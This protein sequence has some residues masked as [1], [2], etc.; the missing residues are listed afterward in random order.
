MRAE[1]EIQYLT[2]RQINDD[3]WNDCITKATNG[4]IY[5]YSNYLDAMSDNWDALVL[6][7]YEAVMPLPWRKKWSV[8]YLYQPF[9]TAQLGTF[10]NN[11]SPEIFASLL[12]AVPKKFSFWDLSFNHQN[13]FVVPQFPLHQRSNFIVSLQPSYDD[14]YKG[15]RENVKRNIKKS[16]TYGCTATTDVTINAIIELTNFQVKENAGQDI[17]NFKNLFTFLKAKGAAKTYGVFSKTGKLLSSCVFFF[18]ITGRI[19][20]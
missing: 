6:N 12:N 15:Y 3:L 8:H 10:G 5:G 17:Q 11:I 13:L 18:R 4:L 9:L 1:N 2:R 7:N 19:T 16:K 14:L 20:F